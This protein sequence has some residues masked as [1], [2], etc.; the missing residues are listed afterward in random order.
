MVPTD[1]SADTGCGPSN[2]STPADTP[3]VAPPTPPEVVP[4]HFSDDDVLLSEITRPAVR[5][6]PDILDTPWG[7]LRYHAEHGDMTA[8]CTSQRHLEEGGDGR[9]AGEAP[10]W[11]RRQVLWWKWLAIPP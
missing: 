9:D 10:V 2:P 1:K 7:T 5:M 4:E 6:A 11:M 8:V 3:P